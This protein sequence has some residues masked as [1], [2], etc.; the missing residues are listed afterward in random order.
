MAYPDKKLLQKNKTCSSAYSLAKIAK[1]CFC[2]QMC[3]FMFIS[4]SSYAKA[5]SHDTSQ[6]N[7]L[8]NIQMITPLN[9]GMV[10]DKK[11]VIECNINIPFVKESLYI[12][13]DSTDISALVKVDGTRFRFQPVQVVQPGMHQLAVAFTTLNGEQVMEQFQFATRHSKYFKTAYSRNSAFVDYTT[14]VK[15]HQDAKDRE[16]S[17]WD[18]EANLATE[19]F[20][21]EGSWS[22]GFRANGRYHDEERAI[23]EPLEDNLEL[24]DFLFTGKYQK[25]KSMLETSLGDVLINES[26]N[27]VNNLSRR[28]GKIVTE[29]GAAGLS[30]FVVRSDQ[31]YG[32]DGDYGLE[33]D[34][35]DH[36]FGVAGDLDLFKNRAN[37]KAVYVSGGTEPDDESFGLWDVAGGTKG[38]VR[39]VILTTDFFKQKL[40]T[41]FEYDRSNYDSDTSDS[42]HPKSD[43]AYLLSANGAIRNF[44]YSAEYEYT[45]LYYQVPGNYVRSDWEGY[46]LNSYLT[47]EKHSFGAM[48]SE[49]NDDV[50]QVSIYGRTNS[51]EYRLDYSLNIFPSVPITLQWMKNIEK[52]RISVIDNYTD[53]YSSSISYMKDMYSLYFTSSYSETND[54]TIDDID[55]SLFSSNLSGSYIKEWFSIQPSI[56]FNRSKDFQ[57][58]VYTDT[59]TGSLTVTATLLENVSINNLGSY[60]RIT[61]NDHSVEQ[62]YYSNDFQLTYEHPKRIW[63]IFSPKASLG[64]RYY[65]TKDK[66]MDVYT[67][68]AIVYMTLSGNFETSF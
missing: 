60:S 44:S 39:A 10:H 6:D 56:D 66:I 24:V 15:K 46:T 11:P 59:K 29:Y 31:I 4:F 52:N 18:A 1:V 68:E 53:T 16:M 5:D 35:K 27:T 25:N 55:S 47:L 38:D 26:R 23:K 12:E 65:K 62:D 50:E 8:K 33:L 2:I 36:I 9:N 48:Y 61:A 37:I 14:I 40:A 28:G 67:E 19:N 49:Y 34:D 58:H 22:F 51:T 30:G 63:G 17:A 45:G 7:I 20:L 3:F 57:T 64:A 42:I 32:S 21:A 13:F 54:R 43:K 41:S